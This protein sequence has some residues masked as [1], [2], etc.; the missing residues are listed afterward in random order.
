MVP[1]VVME[2]VSNHLEEQVIACLVVVDL[3]V[4]LTNVLPGPFV[5]LVGVIALVLLISIS[6]L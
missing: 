6:I 1:R 4:L 2:C 5:E 3:R